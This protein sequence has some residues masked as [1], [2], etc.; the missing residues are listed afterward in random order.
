MSDD[1]NSKVTLSRRKALASLGTI[2]VAVGLGGAGTYAQFTDTENQSATF[3]AGGIDG[4]LS[5]NASYNGEMLDG[6]E[7]EGYVTY[8]GEGPGATIHFQDVKPGDFGSFNFE[9][10]VQDN[11]AWVAAC[12]GIENNVDNRDFEPEIAADP[13]VNASNVDANGN[14]VGAQ[15]LTDGE[16]AQNIWLIPF[17]DSNDT[18]Q[19]F[20]SGGAPSS[21]NPQTGQATP[22]SFW[23][24]SEGSAGQFASQAADG[25]LAPR[26]LTGVVSEPHLDTIS[27]NDG[28]TQVENA[29]SGTSIDD[30]CIMLDGGITDNETTDNTQGATPLEPGSVLNF[31]YDW[32]VPFGVG[33]IVQGDSVDVN[34]GFVFS[35]T[36]HS[37]SPEFVNTYDPGNNTPTTNNS[38]SP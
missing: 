30:G 5:T 34:V 32:H 19:F 31:G 12:V 7:L 10:T 26:R 14:L 8:E 9:L 11:P 6:D 1:N 18:S 27:F 24:N 33:N 23:S 36:R 28:G 38:S 15:S 35:Q 22:S 20:D 21:Y 3:S 2:G 25:F 37:E 16:L 4:T 13:D 17:Y 29:P